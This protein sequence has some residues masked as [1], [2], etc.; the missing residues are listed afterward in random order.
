MQDI[1]NVVNA[2]ATQTPFST[3]FDTESMANFYAMGSSSLLA[4]Y[5]IEECEDSTIEDDISQPPDDLAP[6]QSG[7]L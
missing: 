3:L 7:R 4:C 6:R 1:V 2:K 5:H